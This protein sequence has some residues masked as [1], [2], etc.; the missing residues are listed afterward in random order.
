MLVTVLVL[1]GKVNVVFT[2]LVGVIV[3]YPTVSIHFV[4]VDVIAGGVLVVVM[5]LV[6]QS[7]K[8]GGV[9]VVVVV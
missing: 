1:I 9:N 8:T 3:V 4:E 2:T 6:V 7:V 5:V